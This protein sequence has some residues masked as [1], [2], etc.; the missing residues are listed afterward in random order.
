MFL[1]DKFEKIGIAS[2]RVDINTKKLISL[3]NGMAH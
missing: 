2:P 1:K 3:N